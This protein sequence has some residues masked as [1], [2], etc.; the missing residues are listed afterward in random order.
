MNIIKVLVN[1]LKILLYEIIEEYG[2]G[3]LEALLLSKRIDKLIL[4]LQIKEYS[5]YKSQMVC[6]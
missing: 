3:S 1:A 6:N 4:N 2:I 5:K